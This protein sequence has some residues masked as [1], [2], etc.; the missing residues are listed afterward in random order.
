M[1]KLLYFGILAALAL[2][3]ACSSATPA[4]RATAVPA[5]TATPAPTATAAP[6]TATVAPTA[7]PTA[8]SAMPAA[9]SA[10]AGSGGMAAID[11]EDPEA[12]WAALSG[13]ERSC[14]EAAGGDPLRLMEMAA[15]GGEQPLPD[16][17]ADWMGCLGDDTLLGLFLNV[18]LAETGA[19]SA[20]SAACVRD[21]FAGYD[22]RPVMLGDAD[23]GEAAAVAMGAFLFALSCLND[24]EWEAGAAFLGMGMDSDSGLAGMAPT[25]REGLRCIRERLGDVAGFAEALY[26]ED[27]GFPAGFARAAAECGVNTGQGMPGATG[28]IVPAGMGDPQAFLASLPDDE[29]A[30]VAGSPNAMQ[31]MML[32]GL[33]GP[34]AGSAEDAAELIG[35]LG[36]DTLLRVFLGGLFAG[37][38]P[39]SAA[40]SDCIRA[41]FSVF[42]LRQVFAPE[43]DPGAA[44][45]GSM[46]AMSLSLACLSDADWDVVAPGLELD[47]GA[48]DGL[49]CVMDDL[50][51]PEGL[52]VTL[53]SQ[54]ADGAPS[55]A[56]MAAATAC[57][58]EGWVDPGG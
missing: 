36:D 41:G 33:P 21:G 35:C 6:P 17:G 32:G 4:P 19:L 12:F 45:A 54:S 55:A 42:D 37:G 10:A 50:G 30:C 20:D 57:G 14:L 39:L 49:R 3:A 18:M 23:P 7:A 38:G 56:Y 27:E 34:G 11:L 44:L 1:M 28:V 29:R 48:R 51:G 26:A 58:A 15:A 52:A 25:D 43:V 9:T 47:A 46:A 40:S 24:A 31:L 53:Q 16:G 5:A 8:T 22:L 2:V 13:A